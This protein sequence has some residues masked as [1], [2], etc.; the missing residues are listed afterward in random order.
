MQEGTYKVVT[1]GRGF[2]QFHSFIPLHTIKTVP[3]KC[4][5]PFCVRLNARKYSRT[6]IPE[7]SEIGLAQSVY[8]RTE[9][10]RLVLLMENCADE[11]DCSFKNA[12]SHSEKTPCARQCYMGLANLCLHFSTVLLSKR[13][14]PQFKK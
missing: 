7:Y 13:V 5:F 3:N 2:G 12:E 1:I 11:R 14:T 10:E 4:G 8:D 9:V 6:V